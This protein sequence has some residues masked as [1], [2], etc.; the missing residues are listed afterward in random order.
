ME[1]TAAIARAPSK[2]S[3]E[4]VQIED[5][6]PDEVLVR[7]VAT[8][9]CHTDVSALEGILPMEMPM[10]LGHEGAGIVEKVGADVTHV[11]PGDPVA[12]SYNFCNQCPSCAQGKHTY[13]NDFLPLNFNG[14][15]RADG[16]SPISKDGEKINAF[17]F[18]Q[19][20]FGTYAI[21]TGKNVVKVPDDVPL[22]ILGPLGCG[23]Q[24]GAGAA[25]NSLGIKKGDV[26]TVFGAG[27][28]GLSAVMG[29]KVAG[30]KT[31]IAVDLS[32]DRLATAKELGATHTINGGADDLA[33]EI[34]KV[35]GHGTQ[36][37]LDTTGNQMIMETA[38]AVTAPLGTCAYLAGVHPDMR[39]PVD[40]TFMMQGRKL[41][42]IIEGDSHDA[43][44]FINQ[45]ID[46]YK[47]GKFP[48]DKM[49]RFYDFQDLETAIHDSHTGETIKPI[50]KFA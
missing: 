29:A 1:I 46:W 31:I 24:T 43:G 18:G 42:G 7:M 26:F 11:K 4:K 5:P 22:E 3:I 39:I 25:V 6:R 41:I 27:T 34:M 48:F 38:L 21:C 12:M 49:I 19:S 20:S 40:P 37:A 32:E 23:I 33:A 47:A 36:Y 28:V 15:Q 17:F 35:T 2:L 13:C 10:V 9:L 45:M 16:S 50:V 8:G 30:A 14:L 44:A